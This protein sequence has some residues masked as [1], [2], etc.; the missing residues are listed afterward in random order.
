MWTVRQH[1]LTL[2]V[3]AVFVWT[4]LLMYRRL[5]IKICCSNVLMLP[6]L[7]ISLL[8]LNVRKNKTNEFPW[9]TKDTVFGKPW[10]PKKVPRTLHARVQNKNKAQPTII[11]HI[12]EYLVDNMEIVNCLALQK[13][14]EVLVNTNKW[15]TGYNKGFGEQEYVLYNAT[16][17]SPMVFNHLWERAP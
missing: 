2:S 11:I 1:F 12:E 16:S 13:K 4:K 15:T 14:Y 3:H 17:N 6:C 7:R 8:E 5:K 10:K 9:S